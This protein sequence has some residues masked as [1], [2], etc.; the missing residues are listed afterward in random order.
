MTN[1]STNSKGVWLGIGG[2]VLSTV[3][4]FTMGFHKSVSTPARHRRRR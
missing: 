4:L 3:L 1:T 2:L